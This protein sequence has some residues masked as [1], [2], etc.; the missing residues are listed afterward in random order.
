VALSPDQILES[1]IPENRGRYALMFADRL[2]ATPNN[3]SSRE[4][5]L[6]EAAARLPSDLDLPRAERLWLEGRAWSEL[7]VREMALRQMQAAFT[8]EASR[9]EWQK[10][11]VDRLRDWGNPEEAHQQALLALRLSPKNPDAQKLVD[12][13]A[14]AMARRAGPTGPETGNDQPR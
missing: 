1:V 10:E 3:H 2:Y 7:D 12:Q 9:F 8:L 13:T 6:R 4:K 11:L 14:Q 5:F